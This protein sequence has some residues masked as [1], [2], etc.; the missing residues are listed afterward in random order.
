M[1]I[2]MP[3]MDGYEATAAIRRRTDSKSRLPIVAV[4]AQAMQG[5]QARCLLPRST[6]PAIHAQ[7]IRKARNSPCNSTKD[8]RH[9]KPAIRSA[10]ALSREAPLQ[11]DCEFGAFD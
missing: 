5:D 9:E 1:D 7:P 8:D 3:I 2:S 10:H 6:T 4:T 11:D